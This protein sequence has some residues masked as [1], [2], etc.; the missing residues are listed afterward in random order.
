M[1]KTVREPLL[2]LYPG[3]KIYSAN[4]SFYK[5][6]NVQP[7]KAEGKLI[8]KLNKGQ[9]EIPMLKK[10]LE[11]IL[12]K[13]TT[14]RDLEIE[15][16]FKNTGPKKML[17][18]ARR[19]DVTGLNDPMIVLAIEDISN[20]E[21]DNHLETSIRHLED[22]SRQKN[23]L[24]SHLQ[25]VREEERASTIIGP[26]MPVISILLAFSTIFLGPVFLKSYSISRSLYVVLFDNIFSSSFF[27][28]G[29]SHCP[30]FNL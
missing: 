18:N 9:W 24:A 13:R 1:L 5:K 10:L 11:K 26:L 25:V 15:Y 14:Y 27:N 12:S 3:L 2:L 16:D 6:F 4:D 20:G 19:M 30:L 8:Y 17:L 29:I 23:E 7:K 21:Q 28:K 22:I